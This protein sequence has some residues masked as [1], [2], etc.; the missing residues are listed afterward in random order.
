MPFCLGVTTKSPTLKEPDFAMPTVSHRSNPLSSL[1]KFK[2][3]HY[4]TTKSRLLA[5]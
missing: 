4:P 5:D 3:H 1:W 2:L